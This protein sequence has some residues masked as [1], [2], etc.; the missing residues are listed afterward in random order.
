MA[1]DSQWGKPKSTY[2]LADRLGNIL[3]ELR[4]LCVKRRPAALR[5]VV[6]S[7]RSLYRRGNKWHRIRLEGRSLPLELFIFLIALIGVALGAWLGYVHS[8]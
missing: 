8:D 2:V 1:S 6:N 4:A 7:Q 3:H 5:L